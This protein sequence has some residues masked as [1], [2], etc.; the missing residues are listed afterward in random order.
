MAITP[1][2]KPHKSVMTR[3]LENGRMITGLGVIFVLAPWYMDGTPELKT[4]G[5]GLQTAGWPIM[6]I[7]LFVMALYFLMR[8]KVNLDDPPYI[9]VLPKTS[10]TDLASGK[11]ASF[12]TTTPAS[13][14]GPEVFA[15]IEWRRFEAV[16]KT[17]FG[18]AG[19]ETRIQSHGADGGADIWL[20]SVHVKQSDTDWV[21]THAD[22]QGPV[23]V[24]H[25]KHWQAVPVTD[26]QLRAFHQVMTTH[27]VQRGTY[28]TTTPFSPEALRFAADNNIN[29]MDGTKLLELIASRTPEQ[30]QALLD[31]AF[32][33]DYT[34]P[35]CAHC[36]IKMVRRASVKTR[37]PFWGCSNFPEC[38]NTLPVVNM[39]ST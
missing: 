6:G 14:W 5:E 28:A 20:H 31:I 23:S 21:S 18:Q 25:C 16:C 30:Q 13:T 37:V 34:R 8:N 38:K 10:P 32:D 1:S 35:T 4:I 33:G 39:A 19:F 29:A 2:S 9:P 3:L 7:G 24:V 22:E 36:N 26:Q 12:A 11:V 27:F 15:A 17:L